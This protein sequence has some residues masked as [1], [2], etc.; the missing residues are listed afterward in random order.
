MESSGFKTINETIRQVFPAVIVSS[1]LVNG[2]TDSRHYSEICDDVYRFG[3]LTMTAEDLTRTHGI[4][5]R[6][7]IQ[8]FNNNC[9]FYYQLIKNADK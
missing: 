1:S 8:A 5:E 7:S 4:N 6:V 3:P 2:A 9:R